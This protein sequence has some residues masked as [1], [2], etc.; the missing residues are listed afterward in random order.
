MRDDE[1]SDSISESYLE[2]ALSGTAPRPDVFLAQHPDA[3]DDERRR[4]FTIAAT[5]RKGANVPPEGDAEEGTSADA[6]L[7]EILRCAASSSDDPALILARHPALGN[8]DRRI[9]EGLSCHEHGD[10]AASG[11]GAL[12]ERI[13]KYA[14]MRRLGEGGMG[15]VWL[16]RDVEIDR[17][18]VLKTVQPERLRTG[19]KALERLHREARLAAKLNDPAICGVIDL[20][21][22]GDQVCIV[23]PFIPGETLAQ[24]NRRERDAARIDGSVSC[25]EIARSAA[26]LVAKAA[27]AVHAAHEAGIV[28]RDLKPSNLMIKPDGDPVVLDFGL[29]FEPDAEESERLTRTGD[30]VMTLSYAAPEQLDAQVGK[31]DRRT[32]VHALGVILF[33]LLAGEPPFAAESRRETC[34][35]I[36]DPEVPV[37]R[38]LRP[39]LSPTIDAICRRAMAHAPPSRYASAL[40]LADDLERFVR[41]TPTLARPLTRWELLAARVRRNRRAVWGAAAILV[42]GTATTVAIARWHRES[43]RKELALCAGRVMVTLASGKSPAEVDVQR[44][45]DLLPDDESRAELGR[46][47]ERVASPQRLFEEIDARLTRGSAGEP[48]L[49]RPIGAICETRPLFEFAVA[50]GTSERQRYEIALLAPDGARRTIEVTASA[51]DA[52]LLRGE[53]PLPP[54]EVGA[55][56]SWRVELDRGTREAESVADFRSPIGSFLVLDPSVRDSAGTLPKTGDPAADRLLAALFLL[57]RGLVAESS[58][59][60]EAIDGGARGATWR[61]LAAMA[62]LE[63]GDADRARELAEVR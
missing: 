4:V 48:R 3:S 58:E 25:D 57:S 56:Y 42:L 20:L 10:A 59:R 38:R 61:A 54:L 28:H 7:D 33:E 53:L 22:D 8:A 5:F 35:R 46:V 37:A 31:V 23:M 14:V 62:A 18:V 6:A 16:A 24:R 17:P 52:R 43:E 51:S 21:K 40:E 60:L 50:D 15:V 44:I 26:T 49:L 32:D 41:G 47:L 2:L 13:G 34:R 30:V 1:A 19:S 39:E 45:R 12:P 29:A 36:L 11:A 55:K 27:R 9:L 63:L